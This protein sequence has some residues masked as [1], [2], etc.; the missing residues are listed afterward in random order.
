MSSCSIMVWYNG[1]TWK[2]TKM[3]WNIKIWNKNEIWNYECNGRRYLVMIWKWIMTMITV[4]L[5]IKVMIIEI[6]THFYCK[7]PGC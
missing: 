6:K 7:Q 1:T 3:I 4:N 5:M 2:L